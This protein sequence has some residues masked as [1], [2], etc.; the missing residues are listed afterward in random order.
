[1]KRKMDHRYG[2]KRPAKAA[3]LG[4]ALLGCAVLGLSGCGSSGQAKGMEIQGF[5]AASLHTVL[6]E[7]TEV[8]EKDHPEVQIAINADSSG[9][10]LTQIEEGYACDIFF[11]AAQKQMDTLE[12]DGL[13]VPDSRANV[14]KN[15]LIV[16]TRKDS[17]TKVTG[18]ENLGDASSVALANGSVPAGKYTRQALVNLGI[19]SGEKAPEEYTGA[20]V[21]E[22]LGGVTISDQ[23]NVSKALIAV[24]E[25]ACEVGTAYYSDIYGYEDQVEV[26]QKVPY[27][28]TGVV[29]YPICL[30]KNDDADQYQSEQA[31]EL[32]EFLL[33]DEAKEVYDRYYFDTDLSE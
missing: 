22:A 14:V 25:A 18:L 5:A 17:G 12:A 1:M 26:L 20:E 32:Y 31:R 10:L 8:Y 6:S 16:V 33:S 13:I 7:L 24:K 28:L 15:Q 27:D 4:I 3:L 30:V 19:L 2:S 23:D 29:S 9:T 21:S 11:S